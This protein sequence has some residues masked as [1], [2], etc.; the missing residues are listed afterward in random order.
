MT[1]EEF[2]TFFGRLPV[3]F[4]RRDVHKY[5]NGM[6]K[7]K[8]LSSLEQR[9]IGPKHFIVGCKAFYCRDVFLE[10]AQKYYGVED[11]DSEGTDTEI[12]RGADAEEASRSESERA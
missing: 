2:D 5:L 9:G 10:W 12:Q 6:L 1:R 8:Y 7:A 3:V 4:A 11:D